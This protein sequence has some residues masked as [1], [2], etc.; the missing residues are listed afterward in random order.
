MDRRCRLVAYMG[1]PFQTGG[2]IS[3][4]GFVGRERDLN[5]LFDLAS[6]RGHV[7]IHGSSGMG[8]SS[9]LR[10]MA[11]K[12]NWNTRGKDAASAAIVYVNCQD[13]VPF[14]P[15][16]FWRKILEEAQ[17]EYPT[18]A[19]VGRDETPAHTHVLRLARSIERDGRFLLLLADDYDAAVMT[20]DSYTEAQML[21]HLFEF[22]SIANDAQLQRYSTAV[23]TSR[24]LNEMGPR[25]DRLPAGSPWYNQYKFRPLK[26][27]TK[28]DIDLLFARMPAEYRVTLA[29]KDAMKEIAGANPALLQNACALLL[30]EWEA[31]NHPSPGQF[32]LE[33]EART[34]QYYE[35]AWRFCS[36]KDQMCL[37]LISLSKLGGR[38]NARRSFDVGDVDTLLSQRERELND[39]VERGLIVR[40]AEGESY[41]FA[42]SIMER[43][44]VQ[45]IANCKNV[46]EVDEREKI[47]LGLNR[48]QVEQIKGVMKQVWEQKETIKSVVGYVGKLVG[49]FG[50]GVVA[51]GD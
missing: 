44:I 50:K 4:E 34:R 12:K 6:E 38:L 18:A 37:M 47:M 25:Q 17:P 1:N 46:A 5:A 2:P 23:A 31:G 29:L 35:N 43:W 41:G 22:R 16:K 15:S 39:L 11:S 8:K 32:S 9:L 28:A 20:N 49:A 13:L 7:A 10:A 27:F 42:S 21:T 14:T 51:G 36:P 3:A 33:F 19:A 40:E 24:R 30:E 45:E 26:P 48:K